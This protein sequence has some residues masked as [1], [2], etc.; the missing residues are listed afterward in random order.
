MLLNEGIGVDEGTSCFLCENAPDGRFSAGWHTDQQNIHGFPLDSIGDGV[1]VLIGVDC[2]GFVGVDFAEKEEMRQLRLRHQH[3]QTAH[4]GN[5]HPLC[6]QEEFGACG[7][8]DEI[9]NPF[10]AGE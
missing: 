5:A 10:E 8:V 9:G 3:G 6:I 1:D 7:I 4:T 2:I